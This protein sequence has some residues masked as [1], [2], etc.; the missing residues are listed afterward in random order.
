MGL[1]YSTN[2]GEQNVANTAPKDPYGIEGLKGQLGASAEAYKKRRSELEKQ[3][4]EFVKTQE[5][6]KQINP[7]AGTY[8]G[9]A[10]GNIGS[11]KEYG[12]KAYAGQFKAL[13]E[14]FNKQQ[15]PLAEQISG[16]V[17]KQSAVNPFKELAQKAKG[18][19]EQFKMAFPS[20]LQNRLSPVKQRLRDE[21]ASKVAGAREG[22]NSRG[23]LFSGMRAGEEAAAASG[24]DQQLAQEQA[25]V[26][27][28]LQ[29]Q[30]SQLDQDAI[31]SL[32][33]VSQVE[34]G[35]DQADNAYRQSLLDA[36][37][38]KSRR[39]DETLGGL[40]GAGGQ[41]AGTIAGRLAT[42]KAK[43]G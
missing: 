11:A 13:D 27:E 37:M 2:P 35:Y 39:S 29:G 16:A 9:G 18:R 12:D 15:A 4:D 42:P 8:G 40:L 26:Q 33:N 17:Q 20:I 30:Q 7:T 10:F 32:M 3:R 24:A 22:F 14:E 34:Q 41:L 1:R 43:V 36:L 31:D 28:E 6:L 23:L 5:R 19:A 38:E 25:R 21:T